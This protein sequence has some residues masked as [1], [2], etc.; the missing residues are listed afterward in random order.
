MS[1]AMDQGRGTY[2]VRTRASSVLSCFNLSFSHNQASMW[3]WVGMVWAQFEIQQPKPKPHSPIVYSEETRRSH[4]QARKG[5][6]IAE[7]TG[8][9]QRDRS[10]QSS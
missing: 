6:A 9:A 4:D 2:G 3:A 1:R 5:A 7:D 8:I 10:F